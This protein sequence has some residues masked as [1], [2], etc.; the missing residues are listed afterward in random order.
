MRIMVTGWFSFEHGEA[1]AGDLAA[2]E[3]VHE[4]LDRADVA[5]DIAYSS[6]FNPEIHLDAVDPGDYSHVVF[7]CGPAA[8]RQIE[9]LL[10]RFSHCAKIAV[11]VS[12]VDGT[13][14][15]FDTVLPRDDDETVTP[16]L[17]LGAPERHL[18]PVV[19]LVRAHAQPEYPTARPDDVHNRIE[20]L[21]AQRDVAVVPLDTRVDPREL[22]NR[23]TTHVEA[24]LARADAV[25]TTRLHG[26]V[27]ALR[28]GVPAVA[29]D[30]VSGGGKVI[31][32][33]SVLD[34][35]LASTV[36]QLTDEEFHRLLDEC[37]RPSSRAAADRSAKRGRSGLEGLGE[38]LLAVLNQAAM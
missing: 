35:P 5:H 37:L 25:V 30:P 16:D 1:T 17:A 38:D 15:A 10:T 6:A 33:V 21:L 3:W 18:P 9:D 2:A 22:V 32:Q 29:I 36:D 31:R 7:V 12:V 14:E 4:W 27:L 8:G 34:W 20:G 19:A 13:A 11:G 23:D 26:L 28:H 24:V